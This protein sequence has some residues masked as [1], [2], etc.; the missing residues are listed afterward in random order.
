MPREETIKER[1]KVNRVI[2]L[3]EKELNDNIVMEEKNKE[4]RIVVKEDLRM[5]IE[6]NL[7]HLASQT[8]KLV[9]R[10]G[11]KNVQQKLYKKE[12]LNKS[13]INKLRKSSLRAEEYYKKGEILNQDQKAN[14]VLI[15]REEQKWKSLYNNTHWQYQK[16]QYQT[17]ELEKRINGKEKAVKGKST[18]GD[19]NIKVNKEDNLESMLESLKEK[20]RTVEQRFA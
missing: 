19:R 2:Q 6:E 11:S 17:E 12:W 1:I 20:I 18:N 8:S 5:D 14:R 16:E 4:N 10:D 9:L 15:E 3:V 7:E 13:C